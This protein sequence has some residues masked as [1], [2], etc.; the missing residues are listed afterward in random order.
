MQFKYALFLIR[1]I[2]FWYLFFMS[3]YALSEDGYWVFHSWLI[4]VKAN[5]QPLETTPVKRCAYFGY[6]LNLTECEDLLSYY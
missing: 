4:N 5:S 3:G 2:S 6:A 1:G